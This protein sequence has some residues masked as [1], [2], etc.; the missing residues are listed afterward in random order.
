MKRFFL[1]IL[2]FFAVVS[3]L[4]F[5]IGLVLPI[6]Q[7]KKKGYNEYTKLQYLAE[8]CNDDIL[9]FGSSRAYRHYNPQIMI[10][11]LKMSCFNCGQSSM[12]FIHNYAVLKI[13]TRNYQP[14]LIIYDLFSGC[15]YEKGEDNHRYLR[16]L[17]PY[18]NYDGIYDVYD[19]VDEL[20]RIKI[21]SNL[22]SYNDVFNG[23]IVDFIGYG[24][25]GN[26]NHGFIGT[27]TE[28]HQR[29]PNNNKV[30]KDIQP[31]IIDSLK[32]K[33]AKRFV[34]DCKGSKVIFCISP[35]WTGTDDQQVRLSERLC[36]ELNVPLIDFSNDPKYVHQD[37]YF[38]DET[39]LNARGADE[40]TKDLIKKLKEIM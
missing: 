19:S 35:I 37:Q 1:K 18:I 3:V 28:F 29:N 4:D 40:Y 6:M 20:E 23:I 34:E 5:V 25:S 26:V 21:I 8:Q 31:I 11:S 27:M 10:D 22:Y 24:E 16:G 38:L 7:S 14:K 36:Q 9:I 2:I 12:G 39:H 30:K 13:A 17:G 15:D 32:I 33:F